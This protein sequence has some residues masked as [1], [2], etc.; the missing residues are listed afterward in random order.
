[1]E[2]HKYLADFFLSEE[3]LAS[4]PRLFD[5]TL[6]YGW[7]GRVCRVADRKEGLTSSILEE[8]LLTGRREPSE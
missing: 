8:L 2:N 5:V 4:N 3:R 6:N 7:S 1:M